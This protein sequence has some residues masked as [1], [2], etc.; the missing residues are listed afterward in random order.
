MYCSWPTT[1]FERHCYNGSKRCILFLKPRIFH[2]HCSWPTKQQIQ[3]RFLTKWCVGF[4]STSMANFSEWCSSFSQLLCQRCLQC[5]LM[6]HRLPLQWIAPTHQLIN[7][8][9][10]G[11]MVIPLSRTTKPDPLYSSFAWAYLLS[12]WDV[13]TATV[14]ERRCI[15]L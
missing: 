9:N 1:L 12:A 8:Q 6:L 14:G 15:Y 7:H 5:S 3:R 13:V 10:K 11:N 2:V 4:S